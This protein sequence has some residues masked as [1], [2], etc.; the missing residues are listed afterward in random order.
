MPA[1][2]L[3]ERHAVLERRVH[4][5]AVERH[6]RVRGVADEQH[7]VR[8]APGPAVHRAEQADGMARVVV[9]ER[10]E[11]R[12]GIGELAREERGRRARVDG[13]KARLVRDA[14]GTTWP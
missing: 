11:Q 2:E 1:D 4:A 3:V 6:D 5:L 10:G 9:L 14:A 12:H 8:E 13:R 7:A